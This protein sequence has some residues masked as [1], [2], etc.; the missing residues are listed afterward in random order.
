MIFK[1]SGLGTLC[2]WF[3]FFINT[4]NKKKNL[5]HNCFEEVK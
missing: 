3:F 1:S 5:G 4:V 2:L